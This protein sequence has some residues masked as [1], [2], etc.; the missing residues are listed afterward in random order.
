MKL[1]YSIN[2]LEVNTFNITSITNS[3]VK[4]NKRSCKTCDEHI[5]VPSGIDNKI[6]LC[7]LKS[8][9]PYGNISCDSKNLIYILSCELCQE[10]HYIGETEQTISDRMY[11]HRSKRLPVFII[12]IAQI[13]VFPI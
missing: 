3:R 7:P 13:T 10:I 12:L 5:V 8:T 4:C 1:N 11:G 9:L 2:Q 6:G